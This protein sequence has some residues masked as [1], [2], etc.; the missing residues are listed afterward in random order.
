MKN[1]LK[2]EFRT[3]VQDK[4]TQDSSFFMIMATGVMS[5]TI[6]I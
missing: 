6:W 5:I 3:R 1:T 2:V 4:I